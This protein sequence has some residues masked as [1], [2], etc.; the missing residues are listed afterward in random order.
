M[1]LRLGV[2][3]WLRKWSGIVAWEFAAMHREPSIRAWLKKVGRGIRSI[4][5]DLRYGGYCGGTTPTRFE[6]LGANRT[7]S[8]SYADL[9]ELFGRA[10]LRVDE[11]DVLVDI[12]CGKGRV[13]NYWLACGYR[14]RIVGL[15]LDPGVADVLRRRVRS[16]ANVDIITGDAVDNLPEDGTFF[17]GFNPFNA[18]VMSRLKAKLEGLSRAGRKVVLVYFN[19][20]HRDVFENHPA[21]RVECLGEIGYGH[22]PAALIIPTGRPTPHG[23]G[24]YDPCLSDMSGPA[25]TS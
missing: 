19:C 7:Q 3:S 1:H 4:A 25:V 10:G 17:Y 14:N 13:I 16:R 20:L 2:G 15:E 6:H 22:L 24:A 9:D 21:W 23:S 5:L 8:A 12:G 18:A 11:A